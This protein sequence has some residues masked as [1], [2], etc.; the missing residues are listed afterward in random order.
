VPSA[1]HQSTEVAPPEATVTVLC[2]LWRDTLE[3]S[4]D[5]EEKAL[6][7]P[8]AMMSLSFQTI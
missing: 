6:M 1:I 4:L 5:P 3:N 8:V 7:Q 2:P